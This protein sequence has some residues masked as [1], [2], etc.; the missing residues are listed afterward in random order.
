MLPFTIAVI[1]KN[2]EKH[3]DNFLTA[4]EKNF[5]DCD[6]EIV[7]NDTGSTDKSEEIALS[8]G[9]KVFHSD[10]I[11][12]F[13]YSRNLAAENARNDIIVVLDCDEY[14]TSCK[15]DRL[16]S[17]V[18]NAIG[19]MTVSNHFWDDG[20]DETYTTVLPRIYNRK[21]ARFVNKIH[22]QIVPID[23]SLPKYYD[24]E[25]Y[26]EHF[27]YFGTPEE[28]KSKIEKYDALLLE[29]LKE[30]PD[31]PYLLF[32]LGQNQNTL[33]NHEKAIKYYSQSLSLKV[34]PSLEYVKMM[35]TSLG[36]NYMRIGKPELACEL[37]VWSEH[38]K[39]D[40]D[41]LCMLGLSYMR[42]GKILE[43]MQTFLSA[44][45]VKTGK[46]DGTTTY[47]PLYNMGLINEMMGN[48]D[49]ALSLYSQCGEYAPAIAKIKELT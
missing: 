21:Y 5:T 6:Y 30:K 2:E 32:Q 38:L 18:P 49:G 14:I 26:V 46:T 16:I 43:A 8:H 42:T 10:W 44:M 1:M 34:N 36:Y 39:D 12:D 24:A 3:L 45:S 15:V 41:Y 37:S 47:I 23:D 9:A 11:N 33:R 35:I 25:L 27:G 29:E 20:N 28:L 17:L 7:I 40:S 13:S 4:I 31:D 19:R 22:E 48:R